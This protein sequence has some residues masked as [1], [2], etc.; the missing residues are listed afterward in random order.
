M[1]TFS[2]T[3]CLATFLATSLDTVEGAG[4]MTQLSAEAQDTITAWSLSGCDSLDDIPCELERPFCSGGTWKDGIE[5]YAYCTGGF[6]RWIS[7]DCASYML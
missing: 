7:K 3:L 2:S 1:K 5:Q 4:L 6:G